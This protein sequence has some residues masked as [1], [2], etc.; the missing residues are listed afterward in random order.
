M[1]ESDPN[2]YSTISTVI[3]RVRVV[4][5]GVWVSVFERMS[6]RQ[7]QSATKIELLISGETSVSVMQSQARD[8][9]YTDL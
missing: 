9:R 4:D 7:G 2:I 8:L 3:F 5:D 6:A 1:T